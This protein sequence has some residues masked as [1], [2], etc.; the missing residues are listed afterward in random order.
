MA[1]KLFVMFAILIAGFALN[2]QNNMRDV[3]Y[4]KNGGITKGIILEQIPNESLKIQMADGSVFVYQMAE[5]E[6]IEK[7]IMPSPEEPRFKTHAP[8]TSSAYGNP[9][10]APR[11]SPLAAG[12]LSALIPGAGQLYASNLRSGWGYLAWSVLGFPTLCVYSLVLDPMLWLPAW[13]VLGTA[14]IVVWVYSISNAVNLAKAVNIENGYL[15]FKIGEKTRFGVRPEF[16]Y[17][18]QVMPNGGLSPQFTSGLGIS[19]SF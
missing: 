18:N 19:L 1:R 5:V 13:C 9:Y 14:H 15:S 10:L 2:A 3:V 7:E 17:N 12:I 16:S 4:L 11:K 6:R 8:M